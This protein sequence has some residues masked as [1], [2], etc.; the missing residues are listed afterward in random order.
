[1]NSFW[2]NRKAIKLNTKSR[3]A[4]PICFLCFLYFYS[5]GQIQPGTNFITIPSNQNDYILTPDNTFDLSDFHLFI[6]AL[7]DGCVSIS[8]DGLGYSEALQLFKDSLIIA[9]LPDWPRKGLDTIRPYSIRINSN[10][11]INLYQASNT[12]SPPQGIVNF[13]ELVASTV[14]PNQS[15]SSNFNQYLSHPLGNLNYELNDHSTL[16]WPVY[17]L[18]FFLISLANDNHLTTYSN[19]FLTNYFNQDL[20]NLKDSLNDNLDKGDFIWRNSHTR[21]RPGLARGETDWTSESFVYSKNQKSFKLFTTMGP[22]YGN[23]YF[24][25]GL[26]FEINWQGV[27]LV[28]VENLGQ[29][30]TEL[31]PQDLLES[32]YHF[33]SFD[34]YAGQSLSL[35]AMADSTDVFFNGSFLVR[36][37]KGQR[38]DTA[39]SEDLSL[40]ANHPFSAMV[41]PWPDT[42]VSTPPNNGVGHSN[43][44]LQANG[45]QELIQHS[46]VPTLHRNKTMINILSLVTPSK[47]TGFV[48]INGLPPQANWQTFTGDP[49]WAFLQERVG[50]GVHDVQSSAGFHGYFYT[51]APYFPDSTFGNY[52]YELTEYAP[53]PEDSFITYLGTS[54]NQLAPWEDWRDTSLSFCPGDT[55]YGLA[56]SLRNTHWLW[57]ANDSLIVEQEV[58]EDHA[59]P[60]ALVLP[61][62]NE[63]ELS[64]QAAQGCTSPLSLK[65]NLQA[66]NPLDFEYEIT[67]LCEGYQ[68]QLKA[69]DASPTAELSWLIDGQTYQGP[70]VNLEFNA[71]TDSLTFTLSRKENQCQ[72]ELKGA[73]A[74]HSATIDSRVFPNVL[75]PNGDGLNDQ[76][77]FEQWSGYE[78]CFSIY[79]TDRY[80]QR[81]FETNDPNRC[82]SPDSQLK[83]VYYYV[84]KYGKEQK[85]GF[86]SLF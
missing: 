69:K 52:A 46:K 26:A 83:G 25:F 1:M 47:D 34:T 21:V 53:W 44:A 42:A 84:L 2:L 65:L 67:P 14:R 59:Q 81:V 38:F 85:K 5:H 55:L 17:W 18:D 72:D 29:T 28:G 48:Q 13:R 7:N 60:V 43:F 22:P 10:V 41:S 8:M 78:S 73:I 12:L 9:T 51:S 4:W 62:G 63:L 64:L 16:H 36:L 61:Y 31:K 80:G 82:W 56:S 27:V 30:F 70:L 68:V 11:P 24:T 40:S 57:K 23:P 19:A 39:I 32:S 75:S 54:P 66:L 49:N 50:L 79:I 45:D 77:C 74:L 33:P 37:D 6:Y 15:F 58:F 71:A 76:W 86:V 20:Y 35:Q 3:L